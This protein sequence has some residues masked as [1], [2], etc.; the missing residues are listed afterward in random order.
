MRIVFPVYAGLTHIYEVHADRQGHIPRISGVVPDDP[1]WCASRRAFPRTCG[2][3]PAIFSS[4]ISAAAFSR[5]RGIDPPPARQT[6]WG[7]LCTPRVSGVDPGS[8]PRSLTSGTYSPH[9]RGFPWRMCV[10][11]KNRPPLRSLAACSPNLLCRCLG[12]VH[13]LA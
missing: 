4:A 9:T 8:A 10:N 5:T 6:V 3:A 2:V 12:L 1:S 11:P 13:G 7:S